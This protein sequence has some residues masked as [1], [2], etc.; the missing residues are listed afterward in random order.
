MLRVCQPPLCAGDALLNTTNGQCWIK[1]AKR[2]DHFHAPLHIPRLASSVQ[3]AAPDQQAVPGDHAV[4]PVVPV[5][6]ELDGLPHG[7]VFFFQIKKGQPKGAL[8]RKRYFA[9]RCKSKVSAFRI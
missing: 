5:L 3:K 9:I 7:R 2:G 4:G 1:A 8:Q 6:V